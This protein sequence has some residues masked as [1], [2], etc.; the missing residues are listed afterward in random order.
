MAITGRAVANGEIHRV[1]FGCG[2]SEAKTSERGELKQPQSGILDEVVV[3]TIGNPARPASILVLV[4]G[5]RRRGYPIVMDC[6][7]EQGAGTSFRMS[8]AE[9]ATQPAVGVRPGR[10][11]W[12][13]IALP[14]PLA[15]REKF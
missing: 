14:R 10:A 1:G 13:K 5:L 3:G 15:R 11:R 12:K 8:A 7:A 6:A 9:I 4:G 2:R